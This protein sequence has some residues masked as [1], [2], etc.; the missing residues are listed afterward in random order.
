MQKYRTQSG[1]SLDR[2]SSIIKKSLLSCDDRLDRVCATNRP[3][4]W[5]REAEVFD[6]PFRIRYFNAPHFFDQHFR[7]NRDR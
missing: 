6:S 7:V 4:S 5:F 2:A 3:D 1:I